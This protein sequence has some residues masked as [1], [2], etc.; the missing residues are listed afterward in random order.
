MLHAVLPEHL[1]EGHD[2]GKDGSGQVVPSGAVSH[3]ST[4]ASAAHRFIRPAPE[5]ALHPRE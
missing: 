2:H 5:R 1:E 4:L 3:I